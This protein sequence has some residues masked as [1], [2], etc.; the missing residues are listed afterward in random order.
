MYTG[1]PTAVIAEDEALL[2]AE[3]RE[4]LSELWP[5]LQI[6][7]EAADGIEAVR[8][9]GRFAPQVLFLDI[10]MPGLSGLDV[11]RQVGG[12]AIVVFITAYD[13]HA[14]AAFEHGAL[15]YVPK[16][17]TMARLSLA[18]ERVKERLRATVVDTG[19]PPPAMPTGGTQGTDYLRWLTVP[20]GNGLRVVTAEDISYL[21]ADN[22]Y[23]VVVTSDTE[24][25]VS[26]TLKQMQE[27]LDPRTFWRVHRSVV[28]NVAAIQAIH[29]GFNGTLEIQLKQ[30]KELLPVSSAHA[31]LFKH[32]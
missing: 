14:L 26:S 11:V 9:M 19:P 23:A 21:R 27:R 3:L 12:R 1:A 20:Y 7:A 30:R 8:A 6:C 5:E 16:P 29:R 32:L 15:D 13:Q 28:V 31:H 24:Y 22:K 25:L 2:R 17:I 10:Q 18:V 4:K